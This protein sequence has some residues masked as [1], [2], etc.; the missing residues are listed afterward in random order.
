MTLQ[1]L[2]ECVP[3]GDSLEGSLRLEVTEVWEKQAERVALKGP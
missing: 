2:R 3:D 1:G